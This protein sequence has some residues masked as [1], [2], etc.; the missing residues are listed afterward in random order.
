M[1]AALHNTEGRETSEQRRHTKVITR[2]GGK[3]RTIS[4]TARTQFLFKNVNVKTVR[5]EL[6]VSENNCIDDDLA[7]Q[8]LRPQYSRGS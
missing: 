6:I 4:S 7:L 3:N 1:R 2:N 8:E 5:D